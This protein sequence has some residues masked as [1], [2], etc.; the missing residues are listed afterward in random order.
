MKIQLD[1][2][3]VNTKVFLKGYNIEMND[4]RPPLSFYKCTT[5]LTT[6]VYIN[7]NSWVLV[8]FVEILTIQFTNKDQCKMQ[9][10]L[11]L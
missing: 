10:F 9:M 1:F 8:S 4:F 3:T 7:I 5:A 11:P 2:K 6:G